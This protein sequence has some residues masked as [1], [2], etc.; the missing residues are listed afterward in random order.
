[1][2]RLASRVGRLESRVPHG[3]DLSRMTDAELH[4]AIVRGARTMADDPTMPELL[5]A[6]AR[7]SLALPWHLPDDQWTPA[8]RDEQWRLHTEFMAFYDGLDDPNRA[9]GRDGR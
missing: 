5:R 3:T 8:D 1:M 9:G 7:A 4:A 2:T 6:N